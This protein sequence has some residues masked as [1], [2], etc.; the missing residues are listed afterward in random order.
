[1]FT[2]KSAITKSARS[3]VSSA[4]T[5]QTI[6]KSQS[7]PKLEDNYTLLNKNASQRMQQSDRCVRIDKDVKLMKSKSTLAP[8]PTR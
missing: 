6:K 1:M 8:S 4:R 7:V 5:K 3:S 2:T